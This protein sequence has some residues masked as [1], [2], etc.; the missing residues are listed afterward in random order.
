[1]DWLILIVFAIIMGVTL[2]TLNPPDALANFIVFVATAVFGYV[3]L[4][5]KVD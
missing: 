4:V 5:K 3:Y 1:M 2:G